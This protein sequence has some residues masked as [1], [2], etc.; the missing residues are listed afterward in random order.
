MCKMQI[1]TVQKIYSELK[2]YNQNFEYRER[3]INISIAVKM[4]IYPKHMIVNKSC[5]DIYYLDNQMCQSKSNDYLMSEK[6]H[7]SFQF[8]AKIEGTH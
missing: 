2:S 1:E 7:K 3:L 8:Y 5:H 6:D 4:M